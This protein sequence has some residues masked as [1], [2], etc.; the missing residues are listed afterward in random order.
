M[1]IVKFLIL[2]FALSLP[3]ASA[4]A[5]SAAEIN[6]QANEAL[7]KLYKKSKAAKELGARAKGILIFPKVYKAGIGIG[8][9]YGEGVLRVGGKSVAYYSTASASIGLQLGAQARAQILM[10]MTSDA[11]NKFRQSEGWEVGV[12]G[13]VALITIGAGEDF[14]TNTIKS[15]IVG[16]VTNNQGLM[17]NLN[18]EGTKISKIDR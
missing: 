5:K 2:I 15:P 14:D 17:Y 3:A 6:A 4:S 1:R 10:F 9:E 11:L 13:S 7:N 8:G 18:L 12:D 16:F